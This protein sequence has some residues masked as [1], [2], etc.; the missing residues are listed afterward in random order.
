MHFE[1]L[2]VSLKDANAY[3]EALHRH[4]KPVRGHKFSLSAWRMS[5]EMNDGQMVGVAICGRPIARMLDDGQTIEVL[6]LCTDGSVNACSFLY[7]ACRRAAKALGYKRII[8]YTKADEGG[9]SLRASGFVEKGRTTAR[10]WDCPSR[11]RDADHHEL[12]ERIRWECDL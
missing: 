3:V 5:K 12:S 11:P 4:S 2:T 6:R 7:G 10:A 8:T 1:L 9:A